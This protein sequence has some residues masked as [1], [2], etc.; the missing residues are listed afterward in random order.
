[1]NKDLKT[2]LVVEAQER[3]GNT[4]PFMD[5][6]G[7]WE[8]S[9]KDKIKDFLATEI[10][11]A[12]EKTVEEIASNKVVTQYKAWSDDKSEDYLYD[13]PH[14]FLAEI[15]RGDLHELFKLLS[16]LTQTKEENE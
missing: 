8:E 14:E 1:M 11:N 10:G 3:F 6:I 13:E 12:V 2:K 9:Y 4:P 5:W 15:R 7:D 16:T